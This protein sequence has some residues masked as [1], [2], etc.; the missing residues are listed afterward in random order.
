MLELNM[1]VK[2]IKNKEHSG[3]VQRNKSRKGFLKMRLI[4]EI[5]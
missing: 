1:R 4:L 5:I 2:S 3:E